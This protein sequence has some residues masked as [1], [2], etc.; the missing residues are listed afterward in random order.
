MP[1]SLLHRYGLFGSWMLLVACFCCMAGT[2]SAAEMPKSSLH[3]RIDQL[4]EQG[5][6]G[7]IAPRCSDADFVRRIWLDVAGMVPPS[8][9]SEHSWPMNRR[10]S[11]KN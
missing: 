1:R 2:S 11:V 3:E 8:K 7:P 9:R 6:V 4:L 5:F 10:K